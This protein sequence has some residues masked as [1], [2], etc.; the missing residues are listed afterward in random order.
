MKKYSLILVVCLV[1]LSVCLLAISQAAA[2]NSPGNGGTCC[3]C[4]TSI[5]T[6]GCE[7]KVGPCT[8]QAVL[9]PDGTEQCTCSCG[10]A[11]QI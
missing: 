2:T 9:R 1:F 3:T 10:A 11:K 6:G 7:C 5:G 8:C 4:T